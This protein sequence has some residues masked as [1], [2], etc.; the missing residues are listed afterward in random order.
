MGYDTELITDADEPVNAPLSLQEAV[1]GAPVHGHGDALDARF[2]AFCLVEDLG[3]EAVAFG[4][5]QVHPQEHLGPVGGLGPAGPGADGQQGI[6]SVVLAAEEQ[7]P[8]GYGIFA[9]EL[10]RLLGDVLEETLIVVVL[11]QLEQLEGG[12]GAGF[13][14]APQRQMVTEPLRFA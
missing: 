5:A 1:C 11:G 3:R 12:L 7:V 9:V 8:S 6:S 13:E 2:L 4:P 14:M 10:V